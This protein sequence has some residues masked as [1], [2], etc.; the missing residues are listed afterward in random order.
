MMTFLFLASGGWIFGQGSLGEIIGSVADAKSNEPIV[1]ANVSVEDN[2][3]KYQAKTDF[4]GRFR[5]SAV[6]AGKYFVMVIFE[7]DTVKGTPVDVMV[8]GFGTTGVIKFGTPEVLVGV[9]V[10]AEYQ[11]LKNAINSTPIYTMSTKDITKSPN[12][13]S[14]STMVTSMTPEVRQSEDGDLMFRGARKGDMLYLLDGVKTRDMGQI[15]SCAIGNIIVY[16]GGLPAKYGDTLGGVV[17]LETKSYFDLV[18][19]RNNN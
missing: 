17:V 8:D 19:E 7:G 2:G 4:D 6:P 11:K 9:D 15:P 12:K 1:Y 5:I 10:T 13:F 3:K 14:V 18:R 16:T